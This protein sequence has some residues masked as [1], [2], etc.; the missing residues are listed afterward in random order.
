MLIVTQTMFSFD[1]DMFAYEFIFC[2]EM[3]HP[4][5]TLGMHY[6]KMY[7]II[8]VGN[9]TIVD[10]TG[11]RTCSCFVGWTIMVG[12]DFLIT[13]CNTVGIIGVR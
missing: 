10:S 7:A 12:S 13:N 1:T 9:N 4:P 11:T 3:F 2:S 8:T 5:R 6:T